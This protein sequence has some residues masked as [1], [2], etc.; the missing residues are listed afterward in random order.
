M[1]ILYFVSFLVFLY[2]CNGKAVIKKNDV[3]VKCVINDITV[4]PPHSTIEVDNI[5][6]YHTSCGEKIMTT[7]NKSYNIGDT[8][9]FVYKK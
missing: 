8:I 4:S 2:S 7:R 1:K 6:T 3:V 5:Y 9:I